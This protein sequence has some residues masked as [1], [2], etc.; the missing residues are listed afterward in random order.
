[1]SCDPDVHGHSLCTYQN[2][3]IHHNDSSDQRAAP[4]V[5]TRR[6]NQ[7]P[8]HPR[9]PFPLVSIGKAS[10]DDLI[11]IDRCSDPVIADR[12]YLIHCKTGENRAATNDL[13]LQHPNVP[14]RSLPTHVIQNQRSHPLLFRRTVWN[15]SVSTHF[16]HRTN[17]S[18]Q[19]VPHIPRYIQPAI[20]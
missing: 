2:S 17:R 18:G 6:H 5:H 3:C 12:M 8:V 13:L 11:Y 15:W 9:I 7:I 16:H 19:A 4:F 14:N 1:M 20:I 10:I